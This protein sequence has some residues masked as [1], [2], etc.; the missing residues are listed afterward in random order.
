MKKTKE[1]KNRAFH[2]IVKCIRSCK[3]T[4]H[5]VVCDKMID[6]FDKLFRKDFP[7]ICYDSQVLYEESSMKCCELI[8]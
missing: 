7:D 1:E 2:K 3:T 4:Q 8:G 5:T 6:N